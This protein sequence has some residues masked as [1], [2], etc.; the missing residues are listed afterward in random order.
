[1]K[2]AYGYATPAAPPPQAAAVC[3]L[4]ALIN[5]MQCI[6]SARGISNLRER[7]REKTSQT[8]LVPVAL[9]GSAP[10]TFGTHFWRHL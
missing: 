4:L 2:A 6:R 1:M 9:T 10:S 3:L 5:V 8:V 7:Q